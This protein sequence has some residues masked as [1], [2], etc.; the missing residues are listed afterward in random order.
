MV[1][2]A[3]SSAP[4][5]SRSLRRPRRR[6]PR[7]R[8]T[9]P[10]AAVPR[11]PQQD[12]GET[13]GAGRPG[14]RQPST[15]ERRD[16][17]EPG[18]DERPEGEAGEHHA[19][20][21][22]LDLAIDG[23]A[24]AALAHGEPGPTP[25]GHAALE[26]A[27]STPCPSQHLGRDGGAHARAAHHDDLGRLRYL[28][29]SAFEL[30]ERDEARSLDPATLE[31]QRAPHVED[32]WRRLPLAEC[33]KIQ[34]RDRGRLDL[35]EIVS[36]DRGHVSRRRR[37][38]GEARHEGRPVVLAQE[39]IPGLFLAD[40]GDRAADVVVA[41]VHRRVV[42][43]GLE[44]PER[45]EEGRGA[46][47]HEVGPP[48]TAGE[49]GVAREQVAV[50]EDG[51]RVGRMARGVD[52]RHGLRTELE[53]RAALDAPGRMLELRGRMREHGG[54]RPLRESANPRK[55]VG[56][57]VGIE[58]VGQADLAGR[59]GFQDLVDLVQARVDRQRGAT[60]LVYHEV[61]EA[62]VSLGTERVQREERGVTDGRRH[63]RLPLVK[64]YMT[65]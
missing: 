49:K 43:E 19:P 59:Q 1:S 51:E 24:L 37:R 50:H 34:R 30:V 11:H 9:G 44:D 18:I 36:E 4:R 5:R 57:R 15:K 61:G 52:D 2:S 53:G 13:A 46:P 12:E 63:V 45:V 7:T 47:S 6:P 23:K 21:D 41:G 25:G 48:G 17:Q 27:R 56:M 42:R 58:H 55:V 60:G 38:A 31:L 8:P 39:G 14:E 33:L 65:I 40:R 29:E 20:G 16:G 26:D 3:G 54:T 35:A 22:Q 28:V 10:A 62:P 32:E 64:Q